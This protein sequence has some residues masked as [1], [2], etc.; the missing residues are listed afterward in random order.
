M[1]LEWVQTVIAH[2]TAIIL[3]TDLANTI[4]G[5]KKAEAIVQA[6][7]V[8]SS[9]VLTAAGTFVVALVAWWLIHRHQTVSATVT[10]EIERQRLL[11]EL[12]SSL[13]SFHATACV[14]FQ[15]DTG[16][17]PEIPYTFEVALTRKVPWQPPDTV[18]YDWNR[19]DRLIV[20]TRDGALMKTG[21]LHDVLFWFRRID[22]AFE[23]DILRP[24][25]VYR[26]WRQILPFVTDLRYSFLVALF[27]GGRRRGGEDIESIHNVVKQVLKYCRKCRKQVPLDYLKGRIDPSFVSHISRELPWVLRMYGDSKLSQ[28]LMLR[29][30]LRAL[31]V[32]KNADS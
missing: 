3:P 25:D 21:I 6:R 10:K 9:L 19:G 11:H 32:C 18:E 26:M 5:D 8:A 23:E 13:Q 2:V 16:F 1:F 29:L 31:Q 7:L 27:G 17:N 28:H 20:F 14:Y 24:V 30:F 4:A 15:K 12:E 22:R